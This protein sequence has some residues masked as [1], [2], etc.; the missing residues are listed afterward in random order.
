MDFFDK[1]LAKRWE[2]GNIP[3][4]YE[5]ILEKAYAVAYLPAAKIQEGF[6]HVTALVD[7]LA[8]HLAAMLPL[9]NKLQDFTTYLRTYWLPLK[10]VL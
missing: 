4:E 1:A 10:H 9:L 5:Y 3:M 2:K 8:Q 7:N 6:N